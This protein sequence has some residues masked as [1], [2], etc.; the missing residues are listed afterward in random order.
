MLIT[1]H[2]DVVANA[3]EVRHQLEIEVDED[4]LG[5][6][7][8]ADVSHAVGRRYLIG[9]DVTVYLFLFRAA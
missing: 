2:V 9:G 6:A 5:A 3:G 1:L 8:G 4:G 7:G